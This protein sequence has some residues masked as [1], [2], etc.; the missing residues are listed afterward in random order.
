MAKGTSLT[1]V[2][3]KRPVGEIVPDETFR[4]ETVQAPTEEDLQE[5]DVLLQ[6]HYVSLDPS[7][8]VWLKGK[9][10]APSLNHMAVLT[11]SREAQLRTTGEARRDDEGHRS[12]CHSR[13]QEPDVQGR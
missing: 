6:T 10:S 2:Y 12:R 3:A 4:A 13:I 7:M 8:R 1:Y 11:D 9:S 5:G